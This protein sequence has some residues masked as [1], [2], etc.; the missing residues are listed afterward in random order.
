MRIGLLQ[1]V[2]YGNLGDD[3][4]VASVI[5]NIRCR[6]PRVLLAGLTLNPHDTQKQH[7]I[8]T[9]AARRGCNFTALPP[10]KYRKATLRNRLKEIISK[11]PILYLAIRSVNA[12][13]IRAPRAFA[14]EVLFLVKSFRIARSLDLLIICGGGQLR[15]SAKGPWKFPYTLS[16]WI[17]LAKLSGARCFLINVGAGPLRTRPGRLLIKYA[18]HLADYI[19]FRDERSQRLIRD[20]GFTGN[21]YVHP[22]CVYALPIPLHTPTRN[23]LENRE[24][25]VGICPMLVYWDDDPRIYT[26]LI[27]ELAQFSLRLVRAQYRLQL[28]GTDI[29]SDSVAATD[30]HVAITNEYKIPASSSI[31]FPSPPSGGIN[32]LLRQMSLMDYVVTCRFH[33]IVFAHLLN[34]PVVAVSHHPKM[35]TLMND[36]GL[37]E[38]WVDIRKFDSDLLAKTFDRVVDNRDGIKARMAEKAV[39][40]RR[41]LMI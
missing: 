35:A 2:G 5:H 17:I 31:T 25:L 7:G 8:T 24:P 30:L 38:Y 22:D 33:G 12:L 1:H 26:D 36:L 14:Q 19:S 13:I 21:S 39:S 37:S 28:F 6:W 27:R 41:E 29:W 40:Y 32:G 10:L 9:H 15:D 11:Y 4:T 20:I 3:A 23:I 34:I 18:L 16:K